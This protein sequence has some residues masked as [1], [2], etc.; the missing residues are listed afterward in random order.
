MLRAKPILDSLLLAKSLC[1]VDAKVPRWS[2]ISTILDG[3]LSQDNMQFVGLRCNCQ[4]AIPK[5]LATALC[6]LL[7]ALTQSSSPILPYD[8]IA[9]DSEAVH[10]VQKNTTPSRP[11]PQRRRLL[12]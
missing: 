6:Q 8:A 11:N 5:S 10:H 12:W 1:K 7:R 3:G 4:F 2:S 9:S